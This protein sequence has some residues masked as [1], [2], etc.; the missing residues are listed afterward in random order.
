MYEGKNIIVAGGTGTLGIPLVRMLVA[1]GARVTVVSLDSLEYAKQVLG[2]D[3]EFLRE[4]LTDY[5]SCLKVTKKKDYVF[6]L[7]GIKGSVGIGETKVASYFVPMLRFQTN[8]MDAAFQNEVSRYLFISSVCIYP[9]AEMHFEDNAWNGM[10]KQNDRI[11]GIAKRVGELQGETYLKEYGWDA[12]R[13]LRPSNVYG[14][15]DDFNPATA[16]VIPALIRR[17]VDGENPIKIWGD[18]SAIR[19]FVFS[20]EVAHWM[21]VALEK[22]PP[23]TPINLGS[24]TGHTIKE[25]AETIAR[26]V[27]NSPLIEWD[28]SK[29]SGDPIRLMNMDRAK[30]LLEF[31]PLVSIEEGIRKTIEWY[32]NNQELANTRQTVLNMNSKQSASASDNKERQFLPPFSELIDRLTVDQIKEVLLPDQASSVAEEMET[33][34]HDLDLLIE[35]QDIKLTS[36]L[37]RILIVIAQMNV[38]IWYNKDK[39][40]DNPEQYSELLKLAHQLNGLRNQMK[41][42]LLEEAGSKEKSAIRTNFNTDGLEGWNI[43]L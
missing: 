26:C 7:V 39:M 41:N 22:A 11:P 10:P 27:S 20:E 12:V 33:I 5:E 38:H 13:I 29:P 6:N 1:A 2:N 24:G 31:S 43:S 16:Q 36:R 28:T 8:L 30:D 25:I 9:Q 17:M 21:M 34:C 15:Y 42:L 3:A 35:E 14:P 32:L 37:M 19:D 18:G 23:C 40:Q 4:D